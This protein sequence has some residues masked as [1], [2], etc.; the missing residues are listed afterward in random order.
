MDT[1]TISQ[2][3]SSGNISEISTSAAT[4]LLTTDAHI[5]IVG[6]YHHIKWGGGGF[7]SSRWVELGKSVENPEVF[8]R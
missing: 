1:G 5:N 4:H 3:V 6:Q 2:I 7:Q 8:R